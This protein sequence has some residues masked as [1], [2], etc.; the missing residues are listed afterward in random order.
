MLTHILHNF[1]KLCTFLDLLDIELRQSQRR[2]ILNIADG[3]L[4]CEDKKTLAG[5]QRQ[6]VA[7]PDA[8][9]KADFCQVVASLRQPARMLLFRS[10]HA[11]ML[12]NRSF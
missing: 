3:L 11:T 9:N 8:S 5:L 6:F 10:L 4:V 12:P 7:A 1:K 2:H